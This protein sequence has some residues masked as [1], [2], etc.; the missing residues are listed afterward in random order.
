MGGRTLSNVQVG[1]SKDV[2]RPVSQG[3]TSR[4]QSRVPNRS[5]YTKTN[6]LASVKVH[7]EKLPS[8]KGSKYRLLTHVQRSVK[9]VEPIIPHL[10]LVVWRQSRYII[11]KLPS[12]K[13]SKYR[14]LTHVQRSVKGVTDHST[15]EPSSLASVKVHY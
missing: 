9:G 1:L 3:K 13:G 8:V 5:S 12:V 6:S 14:L 15:L 4:G 7:I 2:R 10:N 11:E